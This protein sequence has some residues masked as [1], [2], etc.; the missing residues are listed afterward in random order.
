MYACIYVCVCTHTH[1][2]IHLWKG[3]PRHS[4]LVPSEEGAGELGDL[5][6]TFH[7]EAFVSWHFVPG[8]RSLWGDQKFRSGFS[9]RCLWKSHLNFLANPILN[10]QKCFREPKEEIIHPC[11]PQLLGLAWENRRIKWVGRWSGWE[12]EGSGSTLSGRWW[13]GGHGPQG[14]WPSR[15]ASAPWGR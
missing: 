4:T 6:R 8:V 10:S 1:T 7:C 5:G 3:D 13:Q 14:P 2:H 15:A 12:A 9:V 11:G